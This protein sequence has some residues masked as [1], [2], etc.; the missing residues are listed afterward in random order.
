[1]SRYLHIVCLDA[2]CPADYGGAIDMLNRIKAFH[3]KGIKI[4]L[5]YFNYNER[6]ETRELSKYCETVRGYQRK[7]PMD[8]LTLN[9]PYFV[10]S[11]CNRELTDTIQKDDHP[12]LL[13]G[14]HTTGIIKDINKHDRK[15]CVRMHNEEAT[16]YRELARCTSNPA[17]KTYYIA[18][19]ILAK[20]YM[21]NLPGNIMY[22]CISEDDKQQLEGQG[23]PQ[24]RYIPAFP[25][26]QIVESKT[27][28]G[29]L[30]L[31]HGKL[32]VPENEKA[33]LWLL[34]NVFNKVR[35]PFVIAGMNP[36]KSVQKAASLCQNTCLV[37]NPCETEMEDLVAKAHINILP[38]FNK[39]ITG[40]RLKLL[41]SLYKGRHCITTPAMVDGTG[42]AAA[43]H[44]GTSA[45]AL[46]S[47][48]SQLYYAPF[49]EEE[50]ELRKHLL[51]HT[52]NNDKNVDEFISYLW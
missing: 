37:S 3:K 31:F 41:H 32:S 18:E 22:A 38:C 21:A 40:I 1:M 7:D 10:S 29:N 30:C 43:C 16:Y 19:S 20:K 52:Y 23:F 9:A 46:A 14:L 45:N 47:I 6:C 48:I 13:E 24:V 5:H 50:I 15:I 39:N 12:V 51:Y 36:P 26:W 8:C 17:K 25:S 33:A 27:G 35:V 11:R 42:L 4:H 34:C 49:E 28:I 44:V 2:P